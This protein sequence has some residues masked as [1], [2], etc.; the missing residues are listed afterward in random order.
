MPII[1]KHC[2]ICK[3]TFYRKLTPANIESG[4]GK[5]CSL[6]C[7]HILSSIQRTKGEYRKCKRCGKKFWSKPSED[8]RGV[9]R[10]YCS[11]FCYMPT[12]RGKAIS[13]DGYYVINCKKVH[14]IIME[15]HLGRKLKS[16]EIVHHINGDKL[17]NRIENLQIVSR[18]EHNKIHRFLCRPENALSS[19]VPE[20]KK[21]V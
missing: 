7:K 17:D 6:K 2:L 9:I 14:R 15:Q 13:I 8:R 18:S 11:R 21:A 20:R 3:N 4:R 10:S 12:E 19:I 1:K 5:V 16:T